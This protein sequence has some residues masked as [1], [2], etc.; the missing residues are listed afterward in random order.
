MGAGLA[1]TKHA[2]HPHVAG[3]VVAAGVGDYAIQRPIAAVAGQF[4]HTGML[5]DGVAQGCSRSRL[6]AVRIARNRRRDAGPDPGCVS[7]RRIAS[8]SSRARGA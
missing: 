8:R 1:G 2:Q 4:A 3:G 6:I 5:A 7:Q